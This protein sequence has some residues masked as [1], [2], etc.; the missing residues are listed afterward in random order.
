[1]TRLRARRGDRGAAAVEFALVA[2]LL[3][4]LV[5]GIIS[6]G[7]MLS[8][9]QAIS[10][11]A[12][13]GVRAA[14]VAPQGADFAALAEAAVDEALS[15]YQ[16]VECADA[17]VT[18]NITVDPCGSSAAYAT[19]EIVYDYDAR[20]LTPDLPGLGFVMPNTLRYQAKAEV[21]C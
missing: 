3:L 21:S 6:Y 8:F 1:M 9:R 15:G 5:F 11:G 10:Q 18:C 13:E 19:V 12:A 7:Y 20:P 2:P 4:M 16:G 14:A 17:A